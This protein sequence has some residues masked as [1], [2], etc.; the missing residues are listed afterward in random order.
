MEFVRDVLEYDYCVGKADYLMLA[1]RSEWPT[2]L[3]HTPCCANGLAAPTTDNVSMSPR[4]LHQSTVVSTRLQS[5]W[6][7]EHV[8]ADARGPRRLYGSTGLV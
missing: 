8:D 5:E 2:R 6:R 1:Y 3:Y 4:N 7:D